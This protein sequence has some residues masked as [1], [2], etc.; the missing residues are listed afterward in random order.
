MSK[1]AILSYARMPEC[2]LTELRDG[3]EDLG[4][5]IRAITSHGSEAPKLHRLFPQIYHYPWASYRTAASWNEPFD[6]DLYE[7][8]VGPYRNEALP[9]VERYGPF[10]GGSIEAE[11]RLMH[12][13]SRAD[14][15]INTIQPDLLLF[16]KQPE[17]G[18]EYLLYRIGKERGIRTIF[19]IT[20]GGL[21]HLQAAGTELNQ[22]L[23]DENWNPAAH[24]I[25]I[26]GQ[27]NEQAQP[28]PLTTEMVE[29]IRNE[30]I[31]Y[32]PDYMKGKIVEKPFLEL[33]KALASRSINPRNLW[34]DLLRQQ[35]G[36]VFKYNLL[37]SYERGA[38]PY[39][40][41]RWEEK[42]I[43][44]PLHY[45]PELT[46]MP[47]GGCYVNQARAI[48]V[49]SDKTPPDTRILVKE[50]NSQFAYT[51][52]GNKNY[53]PRHFYRWLTSIPKVQL[54]DRNVPAWLL[55]QRCDIT[56][57]ITG[58]AGFEAMV[59]G[60]PVFAFG[61]PYY[62]NGPNVYSIG[63]R[64]VLRDIQSTPQSCSLPFDS[65]DPPMAFLK[66]L[67]GIALPMS[68]AAG[69]ADRTTGKQIMYKDVLVRACR[70]VFE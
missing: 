68:F 6:P 69:S 58:T 50:H 30:N 19:S 23:L 66:R 45:Q 49:L 38:T 67:E 70:N 32:A 47:L 13:F 5:E 2:A 37:K 10:E 42:N 28:G 18:L 43:F 41:I 15:L 48:K 54:V 44:F 26:G 57:V 27:Q 20:L 35:D 53:R 56:A 9:L 7:R 17:S 46:T 33:L 3:L 34:N 8:A 24:V 1:K 12:D 40:K 4:I 52:K 21:R 61:T 25:P 11:T 63:D 29:K 22:P 16:A 36:P 60:R 62:L 65:D 51:A 59:H 14:H 64:D 31:D 39:D 55:V